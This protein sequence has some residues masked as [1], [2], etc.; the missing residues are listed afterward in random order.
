MHASL[1]RKFSFSYIAIILAVL[2]LLNTYPLITSENLTFRSKQSSLQGS[3][4]VMVTALSGL[5]ELSE[6][7]VAGAMT[8]V[9][10][11]GISRVLVTDASGRVLYDTRETDGAIGRYAFYTELVQALRGE[12]VFYTEFS[13]KAFKS[14]AASHAQEMDENGYELYFLSDPNSAGGGDAI[15]AQEKRLTLDGAMETEDCVR[16]LMEALLAGP[17]EPLLSSP[18]PEGTVLKSLKV[19]GRRAQIDLS[20]Q[21]ARLTGIDLSLADYCITLTLTQLPNV[22]AVSITADGRELPYRETQVLLSA[23]TLLSSRESGLR[24]ITVSLYFLDSKTGE[25]RAE[26]QTLALYEG[27][28]RVNALLEALAQGPEDDSLVSLLPEDFAV[29]SSRIENGVCY[30]NLPANVSLPENEA[31]RDLMLSALEQSILSLGGVDEVQFLIEGSAE[32]DGYR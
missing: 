8:L 31:E 26:Q 25:L 11:T 19:S 29:I 18:I 16:A 23:D 14:R 5:E 17:D 15:H 27:Q 13:D 4:S 20:A 22:N 3:V 21:Y 32:P 24:P 1:Q 12:D 28:T 2:I 9:E 10:E 7:N 30:L 6:E